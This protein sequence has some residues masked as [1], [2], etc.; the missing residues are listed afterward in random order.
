MTVH[1]QPDP[2]FSSA[3]CDFSATTTDVSPA[4]LGD[5]EADD[6]EVGDE[7]AADDGGVVVVVVVVVVV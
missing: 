1:N 2:D 5:E 4:E 7:E 3:C 6:S